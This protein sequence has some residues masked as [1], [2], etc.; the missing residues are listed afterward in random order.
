MIGD[1]ERPDCFGS[2][3]TMRSATLK[4]LLYSRQTVPSLRLLREN[5]D[6]FLV[7]G[8][9][10]DTVQTVVSIPTQDLAFPAPDQIRLGEWVLCCDSAP[11]AIEL[12]RLFVSWGAI[13]STNRNLMHEVLEDGQALHF[14]SRED[15]IKRLRREMEIHAF[16]AKALPESMVEY[17]GVCRFDRRHFVVTKLMVHGDL[18]AFMS[19]HNQ[20]LHE[21]TIGS[22][23]VSL[24]EA[25]EAI[26]A[27]EIAHRDIKPENLL[28]KALGPLP[29]L[30]LC[31]LG[32]ALKLS[33]ARSAQERCGTIGYAAPEVF[34][35]SSKI[36]WLKADMFSCGSVLHDLVFVAPLIPVS[37]ADQEARALCNATISVTE[38]EDGSGQGDEE[39]ESGVPLQQGKD[40]EGLEDLLHASIRYSD[41]ARMRELAEEYRKSGK[42]IADVFGEDFIRDF[43]ADP[44][45]VMQT[46]V[47]QVLVERPVNQTAAQ[48]VD[49]LEQLVDFVSQVDNA[50]NLNTMGGLRPLFHLFNGDARNATTEE[51]TAAGWVLGT[52]L[53]NNEDVQATLLEE[54]LRALDVMF[55][56]LYDSVRSGETSLAG[57]AAFCLSALLRNNLALQET[58]GERGRFKELLDHFGEYGPAVGSKV[59]TLLS[60]VVQQQVGSRSHDNTT[61]IQWLGEDQILTVRD[62]AQRLMS[63]QSG[64]SLDESLRVIEFLE[65]AAGLTEEPPMVELRTGLPDLWQKWRT[66]CVASLGADEEWC[67]HSDGEE[68]GGQ[69]DREEL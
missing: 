26:H 30:T 24:L 23:L 66:W 29:S 67:S 27:L 39:E 43:M 63:D 53:S 16:L 25:V 47:T 62:L 40:S 46:I 13:L 57:K 3:T 12:A 54:F 69:A 68:E 28:L 34:Q 15:D 20:G 48:R 37:V 61:I 32:Y 33:D 55:E 9:D 1:L 22:F 19:H 8:D 18:H 4:G 49:L 50:V 45:T 51:R 5:G 35:K 64:Y 56:T 65:A 6:V 41:P 2:V 7:V 52:A 59:A 38:D 36:D 10:R 44:A 42:T 21:R 11:N 17:R 14:S 31:D 58:A 60:T